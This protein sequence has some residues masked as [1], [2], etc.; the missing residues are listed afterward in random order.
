MPTLFATTAMSVEENK[1]RGERVVIRYDVSE[2]SEGFVPFISGCVESGRGI[3]D[4][5]DRPLPATK[6][7]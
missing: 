2:V 4:G 7:Q 3:V 5:I 1:G 6:C